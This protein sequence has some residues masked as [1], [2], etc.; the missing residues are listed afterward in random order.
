MQL[1]VQG[2]NVEVSDWLQQ[3]IQKK[4]AKF[5]RRLPGIHE[6]RV[7]LSMENARN[8]GERYVAQVTLR[9]NGTLLR[10]EDRSADMQT[11]VDTVLD[12]MVRQIDRYKGKR[13]RGRVRVVEAP[14]EIAAEPEA[15]SGALVR[16]KRFPV[17]AMTPEEA[18]DQ[19][20]LLGHDF[21]VFYNAED[22]GVNVVYRRR[23][24]NYGLLQ[25]EIV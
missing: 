16:V 3:Y 23:D 24:G 25:P 15:E 21:F 13:A 17:T 11:S 9:S 18:L 12:K 4:V 14:E 6:A 1:V 10:A 20:E 8:A 19:M 7:E 5:G 22:E 2:K